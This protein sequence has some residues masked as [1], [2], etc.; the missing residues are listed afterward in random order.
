MARLD[1]MTKKRIIKIKLFFG[2][3]IVA[4]CNKNGIFLPYAYGRFS[5]KF[6]NIP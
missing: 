2:N 3:F 4:R 6:F 5:Y 1:S